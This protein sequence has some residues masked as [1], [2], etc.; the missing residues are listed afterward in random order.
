VAR[1]P[2]GA[3]E[4]VCVADERLFTNEH[5][6]RLDLA[7]LAVR[8]LAGDGTRRVVFDEFH[9]GFGAGDPALAA[10]RLLAMLPGTWPGRAILVLLLAGIV[11]AAGASVRFGAPQDDAPPPRRALREHADALGRLLEGAA[12][13][14][15]ALELLL[16]GVR[17]AAGPRTGIPAHLPP[18]EFRT[19][20]ARSAAAGAA[21]LAE[22]LAEAE[23]AAARPRVKDVEFARIAARVAA[24]RRRFLDG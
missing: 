12:A 1:V 19:R 3:G 5:A 24:A 21:E 20:L 8:V 16:A 7:V 9:H 14:K 15:E 6:R 2:F 11:H 22:T 13:T 18:A 17:R 10:R 23:A 4:V